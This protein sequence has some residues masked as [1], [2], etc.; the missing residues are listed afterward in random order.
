[1]VLNALDEGSVKMG[2]IVNNI[3]IPFGKEDIPLNNK[4]AEA[5]NR[6]LIA[7]LDKI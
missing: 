3:N 7:S 1:M 4:N 6:I 5:L 2:D